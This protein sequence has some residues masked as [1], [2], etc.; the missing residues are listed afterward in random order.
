MRNTNLNALICLQNEKMKEN[1]YNKKVKNN[2]KNT[3]MRN[4]HDL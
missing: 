4:T 3:T 1:N 2:Q